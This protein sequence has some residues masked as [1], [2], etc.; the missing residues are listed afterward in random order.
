MYS[1]IWVSLNVLALYIYCALRLN[2]EVS[3]L[4]ALLAFCST[5]FAYNFQR[6]LKQGS[7]KKA[8]ISERHEW[9]DLNQK[10]VF[11]LTMIAGLSTLILAVIV[12][13][14]K[15][16]LLSVFPGLMVLLYTRSDAEKKGLRNLPLLKIFAIS[17]V[18]IYVI[19]ILPFYLSQAR[20]ELLDVFFAVL[21]FVYVFV[22]CIPFDIRD[23]DLDSGLIKTLP[24]LIG[25]EKSKVLAMI[26]MSFVVVSGFYL[27][28][29]SLSFSGLIV[30]GSLAYT[31]P[32]RK[33]MFFS[34]WLD[35]QFLLLF[36]LEYTLHLN[37]Y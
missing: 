37:S 15:L 2:T 19:I 9:I 5:L 3:F 36:V 33:E 8:N 20:M 34:G 10:S 4:Y 31:N 30:L 25:V 24:V 22:L 32:N 26:L 13:P 35:G 6:L 11:W 7:I 16:M 18:W 28:V 23:H 17:V 14:W 1:N 12:V 27:D 29:H 21:M